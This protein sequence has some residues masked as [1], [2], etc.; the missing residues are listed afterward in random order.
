MLSSGTIVCVEQYGTMWRIVERTVDNIEEQMRIINNW[1]YRF[2][3]RQITDGRWYGQVL[4]SDK[5][6]REAVG[7][8]STRGIVVDASYNLVRETVW[9]VV[10]TCG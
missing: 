4:I 2:V 8:F 10:G 9:C 5:A 1:S 6:M 3:M 7:P